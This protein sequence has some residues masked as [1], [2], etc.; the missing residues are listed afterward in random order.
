MN[1]SYQ[2]NDLNPGSGKGSRDVEEGT[3]LNFILFILLT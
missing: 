2:K 1:N 3:D